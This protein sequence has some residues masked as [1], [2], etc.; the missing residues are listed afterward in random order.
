MYSKQLNLK[1][2]NETLEKFE[3][4]CGKRKESKSAV[5]RRLILIELAKNS[6]LDKDTEKAFGIVGGNDMVEKKNK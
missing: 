1:I 6:F 5:I 3:K 2:S 4:Y